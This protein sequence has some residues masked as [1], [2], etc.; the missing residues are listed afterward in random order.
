MFARTELA[1]WA[2]LLIAMGI[3]YFVCLKASKEGTK[4]FQLG[5]YIIGGII[6]GL[7]L[8]FAVS[9]LIS[10]ISRWARRPRRRT[11]RTTRP[12]TRTRTR[13]PEIPQL[14]RRP[15]GV[16]EPGAAE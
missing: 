15:V 8:I 5:G 3:A 6:L 1:A 2:L 11:T 14:P 9:G 12:T 10:S 16:T 4:L 7:S 13:T